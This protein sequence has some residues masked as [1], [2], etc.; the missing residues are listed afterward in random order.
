M[1]IASAESGSTWSSRNSRR[2]DACRVPSA[3]GTAFTDVRKSF[4]GAFGS[5]LDR[6][7]VLVGRPGQRRVGSKSSCSRT[8]RPA[9]P[10]CG[11]DAA[12][13]QVLA[14]DKD[15][16]WVDPPASLRG[17]KLERPRSGCGRLRQR[18]P[19]RPRRQHRSAAGW[20]SWHNAFALRA[21]GSCVQ[22]SA[23][24]TGGRRHHSCCRDNSRSVREVQVGVELSLVGGSARAFRPGCSDT[25]A[26]ELIVRF[27]D[28]TVRRIDTPIADRVLTVER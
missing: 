22:V 12:P 10:T 8:A 23:A 13:L 5:N 25:S 6:L 18:R 19:G 9:P 15:G 11:K 20:C 27:P 26:R 4:T 17:L 1:G 28:G 24:V 16:R 14:L 21:T 2:K 3:K 7:G